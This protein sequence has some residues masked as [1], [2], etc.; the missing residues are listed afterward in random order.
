MTGWPTFP[1]SSL[2]VQ[3]PNSF[4]FSYI[5]DELIIFIDIKITFK[6]SLKRDTKRDS[7]GLNISWGPV[8][9]ILQRLWVRRPML[10]RWLFLVKFS[11]SHRLFK[12]I[13][14]TRDNEELIDDRTSKE[15][16]IELFL[17]KLRYALMKSTGKSEWS[18]FFIL[19]SLKR[20]LCED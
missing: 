4:A 20:T 9:G 6:V 14:L 1:V 3:S 15:I 19:A 17:L 16:F 18:S 7:S 10:I 8:F 5:S 11:S 12:D 13:I 2:E